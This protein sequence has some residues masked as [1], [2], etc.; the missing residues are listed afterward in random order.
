[1]SSGFRLHLLQTTGFRLLASGC[2]LQALGF[3]NSRPQASGFNNSKQQA[4]GLSLQELVSVRASLS[5][6]SNPDM[7]RQCSPTWRHA[8]KVEMTANN[9][10]GI[11][12]FYEAKSASVLGLGSWATHATTEAAYQCMQP[13]ECF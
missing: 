9:L 7:D 6:L 3:R 1:M 11:P 8:C 5:E 4:K 13:G 10:P 2:M 12:G